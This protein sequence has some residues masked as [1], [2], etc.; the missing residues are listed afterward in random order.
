M[1]KEKTVQATGGIGFFGLLAIV[2]ITLKLLG[3]IHWNWI[4]V[5]APL[6]APFLI[7]FAIL[8]VVVIVLGIA[9]LAALRD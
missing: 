1:S 8:I 6:W 4:W 7:T 3:V 2:F 9:F 5:L